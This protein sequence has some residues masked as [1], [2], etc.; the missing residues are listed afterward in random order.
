[1]PT[2]LHCREFETA[3]AELR[4]HGVRTVP[5]QA[6]TSNGDAWIRKATSMASEESVEFARF[7]GDLRKRTSNPDFDLATTRDV[8]E[9]I[10][11]ATREPEDVTYAETDA[12]GV[13]ALWCI[14]A[15]SDDDVVLLHNHMGGSVVTSMHSDRKAAA[16]I[17]KAAGIKSLVIDYRRAPEHKF[18]AQLDDVE[19]A[20]NWLLGQ[21]YRSENIASV[22]HS[23]GGNL[24]VS[25]AL[26]LRDGGATL[27]GAVL[28]ISPW[29]DMSLTNAS[30]D[31]N[32]GV[33]MLLSRQ[34][35]EIFRS[36]LLDGTDVGWADPRVNLLR[37]D[38]HGLPP[39]AVFYGS[40]ELLAGEALDFARQ[41]KT[42]GN[43]VHVRSV[44][45]GQ[46]SFI[47]GAGRVPEVDEAITEMGGW[48]R[49]ILGL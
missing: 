7:F 4:I 14:P 11:R 1:L 29:C 40:D 35:L 3:E 36:A 32:A 2:S 19:T 24:A 45:A 18:P 34:L 5:R 15:D 31:T 25:L 48:L 21:G 8:V 20:F 16:H 9:S 42:V 39:T 33:D 37:A 17:A 49:S 27:P 26:R 12:D 10:H 41:A 30:I 46:H 44:P 43:D 6:K 22:G 28:A 38:L 47:M 23:I 13:E